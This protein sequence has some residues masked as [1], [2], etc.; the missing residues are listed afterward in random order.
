[1][2]QSMTH[3]GVA[4]GKKDIEYQG[5][6]RVV[7]DK[8][9]LTEYDP[10]GDGSGNDFDPYKEYGI[11]AERLGSFEVYVADSQAYVARYDEDKNAIRLY[12]VGT[13]E[14]GNNTTVNVDLRVV[15]E[16]PG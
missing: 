6:Y 7:Y 3:V 13:G 14:V 15:V 12:D 11:S 9:T 5:S 8:W 2:P 4:A 10:D 1:M 16:G